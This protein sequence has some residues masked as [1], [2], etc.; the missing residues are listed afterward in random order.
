MLTLVYIRPP[1]ASTYLRFNKAV[2]ATPT[3]VDHIELLGDL[4][5]EEEEI[6][7]QELHLVHGLFGVHGL[8]GE[9]LDLYY[10]GRRGFLLFRGYSSS[11]HLPLRNPSLEALHPPF[12]KVSHLVNGSKEVRG[13]H[14]PPEEGAPGG[15]EGYLGHKAVLGAAGGLL[16]QLC[17]DLGEPWP[18]AEDLLQAFLKVVRHLWRDFQV[19]AGD[20][21][22]HDLHLPGQG[23][24]ENG[25]GPGLLQGLSAGIQGSASG[26]NVVHQAE[27]PALQ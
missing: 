15:I 13:P 12:Q 5:E 7:A 19:S 8:D 11:L 6:M 25:F 16:G 3:A 24:A 21:K 23:K 26:A 1:G 17:I 18:A 20:V 14:L 4:V 22:L 27:V 2:A 10:R 9:T